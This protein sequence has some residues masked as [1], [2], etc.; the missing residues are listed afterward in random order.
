MT[1]GMPPG[2]L[3]TAPKPPR[4]HWRAWR[5]A[6][7][8]VASLVLIVALAA[9]IGWWRLTAT[10]TAYDGAH[11]NRGRNA[12]WVAHTWVGDEHSAG[13]YAALAAQLEREQITYVFAHVGPLDGDGSI[14]A[15]RYP[16]ARQFADA[17]HADD[18]GVMILA[19]MGQINRMGAQPGGSQIDISLSETRQ[20]IADTAAIFTNTLDFD[21]AHLDIEPI[22]N[23]D[24]HF[25]D[26]LDATRASM[27]PGKMLSI[28]TPNWVPVARASE[29]FDDLTRHP[30]NW[31]TTYYFQAVSHH[32]DQIVVML[33]NTSM[34]TAPLYEALV[35]QETANV[36]RDVRLAGA[37]TAVII[38]IPTYT[39]DSR[40]FHAAAENMR[41]GLTGVVN[42][43]NSGGVGAA[44][45]G[46]AIYPKWLTTDA[47]WATYERLWLGQ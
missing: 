23:N 25:L 21:G 15:E 12:T 9:E 7:A 27:L 30:D 40:I 28:A 8:V 11:F 47:D 37:N 31:W 42:G 35:Q 24:N 18:P 3:S 43:L 39:G 34:P 41:T 10:A 13:D 4:P 6:L 19:W 33:Y 46:V 26:L 5:V 2:T 14:P 17:L 38:G 36:L 32:V 16:F 20:R 44:F 29:I 1:Q 22:L 45:D